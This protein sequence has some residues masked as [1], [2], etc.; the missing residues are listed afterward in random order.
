MYESVCVR[1]VEYVISQETGSFFT[2]G[3]FCLRHFNVCDFKLLMLSSHAVFMYECLRFF[4]YLII[5][6]LF[7]LTSV[8]FLIIGFR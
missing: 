6:M 3:L 1:W 4:L 5:L 8:T 2:Y 7:I